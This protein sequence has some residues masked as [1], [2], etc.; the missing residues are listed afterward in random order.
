[1]LFIHHKFG[2]AKNAERTEL[3]SNYIESAKLLRTDGLAGAPIPAA[4]PPA[5]LK[6]AAEKTGSQRWCWDWPDFIGF[7]TSR[8][9]TQPLV[10]LSER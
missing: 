8:G 5:S 2:N 9:P 3:R 1:M 4:L 6:I 10:S 7:W